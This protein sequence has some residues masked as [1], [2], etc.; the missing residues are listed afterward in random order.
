MKE[1]FLKSQMEL[2]ENG[3]SI[4]ENLFSEREIER[5]D[6]ELSLLP[7]NGTSFLI[8]KDLFAVRRFID[9]APQFVPFLFSK[10]SE[11]SN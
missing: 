10:K 8:T 1:Q 6:Q 2:I 4:V 3:F 11:G 7:K 9:V 5:L